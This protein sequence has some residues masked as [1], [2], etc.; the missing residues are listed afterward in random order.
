MGNKRLDD[1]ELQSD[2]DD[3]EDSYMP[4]EEIM[5][6]YKQ[7]SDF[8]L[9][10]KELKRENAFLEDRYSRLKQENISLKAE[11]EEE[12]KKVISC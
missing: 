10:I 1:N 8:K 5:L 4:N 7:I 12:K 3:D 6:M 11:I 9:G 2:D